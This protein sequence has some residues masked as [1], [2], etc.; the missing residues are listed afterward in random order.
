MKQNQLSLLVFLHYIQSYTT[1]SFITFVD[2][3]SSFLNDVRSGRGPPLGCRHCR[4]EIQTRDR[5]T[6]AVSLK[7]HAIAALKSVGRPKSPL[8]ATAANI[9]CTLLCGSVTLDARQLNYPVYGH[10][11]TSPQTINCCQVN[12][13][14]PAH[15]RSQLQATLKADN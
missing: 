11:N 14:P 10:Y 12:K 7:S 8:Q 15:P 2:F 3:R 9:N 5:L 13:I 1:H 6:A 4:A